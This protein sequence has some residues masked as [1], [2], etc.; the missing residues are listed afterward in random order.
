[1]KTHLGKTAAATHLAAKMMKNAQRPVCN[2]PLIVNVFERIA[3]ERHRQN[4]LVAEGKLP[5]N[6]CTLSVDPN[7]KLR[8]LVEEVG[9]VAEAIDRLE[10]GDCWL[11]R[12]HL[13]D[14]LVHVAAVAVAWLEALE[15]Q[16]KNLSGGNRKPEKR[17]LPP[18]TEEQID[19]VLHGRSL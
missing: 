18:L 6:C 1:M 3:K 13:Q 5:W 14:E 17:K 12:T 7:R 4:T 15:L 8:V 10:A 19:T 2:S 16:S 9:E 11:N